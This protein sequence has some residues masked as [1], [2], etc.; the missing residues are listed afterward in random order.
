MRLQ[1]LSCARVSSLALLP[2]SYCLQPN[3]KAFALLPA[4]ATLAG[5]VSA[6]PFNA[7]GTA[8][9]LLLTFAKS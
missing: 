4:T 5:L 9:T 8:G 3:M 2:L 7:N 6:L 1:D